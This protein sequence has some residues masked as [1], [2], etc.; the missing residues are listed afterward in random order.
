[1]GR[2]YPTPFT[3]LVIDDEP[4]VLETATELLRSRG[5]H[6]IAALGGENGLARARA[7]HPDLILV[8]YNM[9]VLNGPAVVVQ[10]KA[11][12]TTRRTPVVALTSGSADQAN[13]LIRV[14]CIGFIPKPFEPV[15]FLNI[16]AEILS[17]TVGRSRRGGD[18]RAGA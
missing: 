9:P 15:E 18:P 4:E 2:P 3:I 8:D 6:V 13:E 16:V 5:H 10:L 12:T 7:D 14:G 17:E 1:M 11:D